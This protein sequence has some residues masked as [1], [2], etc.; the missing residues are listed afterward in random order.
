MESY[1]WILYLQILTF[2]ILS[3]SFLVIK[4]TD[5]GETLKNKSLKKH[6]KASTRLTYAHLY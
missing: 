6:K 4:V 1:L 2:E 3:T 5:K